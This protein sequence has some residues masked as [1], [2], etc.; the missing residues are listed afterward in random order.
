MAE[1]HGTEKQPPCIFLF[2][3]FFFSFFSHTFQS[4]TFLYSLFIILYFFSHK[5]S[6]RCDTGKENFLFCFIFLQP[7]ENSLKSGDLS[8]LSVLK[9]DRNLHKRQS[10]RE[11]REKNSLT[12]CP[13]IKNR[14]SGIAVEPIRTH[15]PDI[16]YGRRWNPGGATGK[17][18]G[19]GGMGGGAFRQKTEVRW[20]K[21]GGCAGREKKRGR[22]GITGEGV[23][24]IQNTCGRA[25][26][27]GDWLCGPDGGKGMGCGVG[28]HSMLGGW[29]GWAAAG[30]APGCEGGGGAGKG[31]H[32]MC[33]A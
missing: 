3:L 7:I 28:D 8:P 31:D 21:G 10:I 16:K 30:C 5:K 14:R 13:D 22:E 26:N 4:V 9:L 2:L 6:V 32:S 20:G 23:A 15:S 17:M 27:R 12:Q 11:I 33:C 24:G 29:A 19:R 18:K 25:G 1:K